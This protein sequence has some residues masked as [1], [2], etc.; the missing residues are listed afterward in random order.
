MVSTPINES[1]GAECGLCLLNAAFSQPWCIQQFSQ[2][3]LVVVMNG[4]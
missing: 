4:S 1:Q 3:R 2:K